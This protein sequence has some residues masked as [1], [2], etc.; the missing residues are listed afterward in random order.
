MWDRFKEKKKPRESAPGRLGR[1]ASQSVGRGKKER[2]S[3][4]QQQQQQQQPRISSPLPLGSAAVRAA[5]IN[6]SLRAEHADADAAPH[7]G[8]RFG[9]SRISLDA[10]SVRSEKGISGGLKGVLERWVR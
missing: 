3:V 7:G 1:S 2:E 8:R 10:R 6:Q 9:A 5:A 4:Q